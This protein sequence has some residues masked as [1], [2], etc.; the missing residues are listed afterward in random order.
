MQ[1]V[2]VIERPDGWEGS[3]LNESNVITA[4]RKQPG[5]Q[6]KAASLSPMLP[7]NILPGFLETENNPLEKAGYLEFGG[8]HIY[9][10]LHGVPDPIARVL[11]VGPFASERYASYIPWV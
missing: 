11:L 9:S 7:N 2:Q 1:L 10:V 6:S 3:Y 8:A 4:G 5:G